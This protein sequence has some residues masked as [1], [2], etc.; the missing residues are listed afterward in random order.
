MRRSS[1]IVTFLCFFAVFL[2]FPLVM[3][4]GEAAAAEMKQLVYDDAG[5]L[6]QEEYDEL[7]VMANQYGVRRETDIIILTSKNTENADVE[8]MTEDFYDKHALG[9]DKPHGNAVILT[10]DMKNREVYLAGFYKAKMYLDDDRLDK[11]R[12]K[13]IPDIASGDYMLAFQKYIQTA[14]KYMGF[15]PDMNPDN[16]LFNGWFQLAVS[17]IIGGIIVGMMAI[18]SGGRVTVNR[19]TY[20]DAGT[21]GVLEHRDQY[22]HTTVTKQKIAKN[23]SGGSGGGGTTSG[24]HSHSGSR[25]SF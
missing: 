17:L 10:L 16:L 14:D 23:N 8:K 4:T 2:A 5:L 7:N 9:Y 20:E 22:L 25:G 21:S 11:V 3:K 24:G 19:Q 6:N 18:R 1:A 15:R 13:I 12:A